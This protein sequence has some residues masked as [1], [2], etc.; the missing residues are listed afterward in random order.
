MAARKGFLDLPAELRNVVYERV[1][2]SYDSQ[3][4]STFEGLACT[5]KPGALIDRWNKI[6]YPSFFHDELFRS[7]SAIIATNHQIHSEFYAVLH[8]YSVTEAA[9][10]TFHIL[11][12]DFQPLIDWLT[13][14]PD[15]D[16]SRFQ[17]NKDGTGRVSDDARNIHVALDFHHFT[18]VDQTNLQEWTLFA[19]EFDVNVIDYNVVTLHPLRKEWIGH[20]PSYPE[21]LKTYRDFVKSFDELMSLWFQEAEEGNPDFE[22]EYCRT[23]WDDIGTAL[24]HPVREFDRLQEEWWNSNEED[25]DDHYGCPFMDPYE[26]E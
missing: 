8:N 9:I 22:Y 12:L 6:T 2:R 24:R 17:K 26:Y 18:P 25:S 13:S 7:T 14:L 15:A 10:V 5:K 11:D 20:G 4:Y 21:W 19:G 3:H 23:C 16:R 1:A